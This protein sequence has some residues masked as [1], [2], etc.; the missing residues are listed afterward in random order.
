[1]CYKSKHILQV[2]E[3]SDVLAGLVLKDLIKNIT[4]LFKFAHRSYEVGEDNSLLVP[5][6]AEEDCGVYR[7]TLW[8]PLGHYIQEGNTEYYSAGEKGSE[9]TYIYIYSDVHG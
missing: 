7:C 1:V 6:P 4:T 5:G 9:T 8:P 2:E 3:G